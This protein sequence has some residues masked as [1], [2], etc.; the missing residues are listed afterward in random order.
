[1]HGPREEVGG[2]A[3]GAVPRLRQGTRSRHTPPMGDAATVIDWNGTDVPAELA[4]VP[5][6]RYR[7]VAVEAEDGFELTPALEAKIERGIEDIRAGRT[8][9]WETV[10]AEIAAKIAAHPSR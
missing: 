1:M 10:K 8:V 9:P 6:G 3:C 5:P 2:T 4:K 7:L